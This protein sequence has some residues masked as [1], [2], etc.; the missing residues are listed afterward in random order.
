MSGC[1]II[2]TSYFVCITRR[3]VLLYFFLYIFTTSRINN[4]FFKCFVLFCLLIVGTSLLISVVWLNNKSCVAIPSI[5]FCYPCSFVV[6]QLLKNNNNILFKIVGW[7][8]NKNVVR[9]LELAG[10]PVALFC[11]CSQ[12]T[13]IRQTISTLFSLVAIYI[14][15]CIQQTKTREVY[16]FI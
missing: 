14:C 10:R 12:M 15:I 16:T 9:R 8:F 2:Q 7:H 1:I 6:V 3:L 11:S 5:Q 13:T 4:L